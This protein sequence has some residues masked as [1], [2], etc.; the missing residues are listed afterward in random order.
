MVAAV[1]FARKHKL[2]LVIKGGGHSYLGTSNAPDSLLIWTRAMNAITL[3]DAF[4]GEGCEGRVAPQPAVTVGAGAI[5]MHVYDEV[6]TR[7]GRYVQGGGCGTVGVAGLVQGGGFGSYSKAYG[8]AAASLIEAEIV[9]ADGVVRIAKDLDEGIESE[10]VLLVE[11]IVDTGFTLRY[12]LQT[13]ASRGPNSLAI[14]S[15]NGP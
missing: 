3:H 1:D 4:V 5:W 13:L 12:L 6:T 8:T 15:M 10:D 2:R 9:T 7:G 14:V 11:V